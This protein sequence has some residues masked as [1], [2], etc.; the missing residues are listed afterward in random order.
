MRCWVLSAS[1]SEIPASGESYS[2][3]RALLVFSQNCFVSLIQ[4]SVLS[5]VIVDQEFEDRDFF[6]SAA[7]SNSLQGVCTENLV[8]G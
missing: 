4:L 3:G 8:S 6:L 1:Y 7:A 2:S 5:L